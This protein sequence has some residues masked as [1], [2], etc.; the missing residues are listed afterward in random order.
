MRRKAIILV[1]SAAVVFTVLC[2]T[3]LIPVWL[4]AVLLA[5]FVLAMFVHLGSWGRTGGESDDR[6]KG[7]SFGEII[8]SFFRSRSSGNRKS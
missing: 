4:G 8:S 1:L 5:V 6:W 2:L 7:K 3:G